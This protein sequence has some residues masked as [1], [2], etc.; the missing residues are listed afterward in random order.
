MAEHTT[1][2]TT[3]SITGAAPARIG[4]ARALAGGSIGN[5]VE[6][7]DWYTYSV[8]AIYFSS[9]FFPK[10]D[11]TAQLLGA[12]AIFAVGFFMRPVGGWL[13]GAFAD[14]YGRRAGLMLTILLMSGG[15]LL[16][17]ISPTY[18]QVG[19][20]APVIL[21]VARLVQGLSV[22]G[23]FASSVT[24]LVEMAPPGRRGL[25]GSFQYVSTTLG[26]LLALLLQLALQATLT[27]EQLTDWGWRIPFLVGAVGALVGLYIRR[28]LPDTPAYERAAQ[29]TRPGGLLRAVVEYPR[30]FALVVGITV[31]GTITYYTFTTYLKDFS[32]NSLGLGKSDAALASLVALVFFAALQPL[33]GTLSDRVGRKPLLVGFAAAFTLLSVPIFT[34]VRGTF[35]SVLA[36]SLLAVVLLSGYTA[37]AAAVMAEIFP[38]AVRA[39]GIGLPYSLTVAAFGGTAPY[40]ALWFKQAGHET[41]FFWYVAAAALVSLLVYLRLPETARRPLE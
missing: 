10:A 23:E 15:A 9:Q 24:F 26:Q 8:F 6:W 27:E 14:R 38:A 7:F 20:L 13:L 2:H 29:R 19:L 40:V 33:A 1:E 30:Q 21:L 32:I 31:A 41:W 36:F 37:I 5:L 22:G 17:A 25:F 34:L 16:V 12:F 18:A 28:G 39:A 35:G 11:Q 4:T 3:E